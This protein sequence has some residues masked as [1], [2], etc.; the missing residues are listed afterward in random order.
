MSGPRIEI[1]STEF[2]H[3]SG[4]SA[5]GRAYDVKVQEGYMHSGGR[6][7]EKC[8]VPVPKDSAGNFLAPYEPGFY[9]VAASSYEVRDGR[10]A[11]N[12]YE[13]LLVRES[14]K[15]AGKA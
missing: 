14:D 5:K 10:I 9:G 7:P 6:Y 11:I 8:E 15:P 1:V 3:F 4:T 2:K 13:L 12:G